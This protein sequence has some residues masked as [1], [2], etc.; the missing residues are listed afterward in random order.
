MKRLPVAILPVALALL[1]CVTAK[2]P[3]PSPSPS[4]LPI[5]IPSPS[6]EPPRAAYLSKTD[7]IRNFKAETGFTMIEDAKSAEFLQ[8]EFVDGSSIKKF[9]LFLG[10]RDIDSIL[11]QKPP[12]SSEWTSSEIYKDYQNEWLNLQNLRQGYYGKIYPKDSFSAKPLIEKGFIS[13]KGSLKSDEGE[14]RMMCV[15]IDYWSIVLYVIDRKGEAG[16]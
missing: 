16:R 12:F 5:P 15:N 2:A 8:N 4:P 1:G 9:T 11:A 6:P 10:E 13:L 14:L 3:A 7:I